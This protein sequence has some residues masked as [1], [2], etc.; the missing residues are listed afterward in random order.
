MKSVAG[1]LAWVCRQCRPDLSYRVSRIQSASN[2]GTVADIKEA[3][4]TVESRRGVCGQDLSEGHYL[5]IRFVGLEQA[6]RSDV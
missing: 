6:R 5:Q 1:S 3:N 2:N 4:K